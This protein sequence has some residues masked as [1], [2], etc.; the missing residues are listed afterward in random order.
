MTP[1]IMVEVAFQTAEEISAKLARYEEQFRN[2]YTEAYEGYR[3]CLHN[4]EKL[5]HTTLN[6]V[7]ILH[8]TFSS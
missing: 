6:S 2:R 4:A 5:A 3:Q 1:V 7:Q 8:S